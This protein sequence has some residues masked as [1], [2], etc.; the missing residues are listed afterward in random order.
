MI[1]RALAR[2]GYWLAVAAL[3]TAT[4]GLGAF[5]FVD[6]VLPE[7]AHTGAHPAV[8]EPSPS[9]GSPSASPVAGVMPGMGGAVPAN[10]DCSACHLTNAGAI[11]LRPIPA[12]GHPLDGWTKCTSCHSTQSLVATAPGHTGIHATACLTCHKPGNLPA[13]LS[14]P[15]R[16]RQNTACLDCHGSTAPLPVDMAHRTEQ[17][18]W[19]CH[20]LPDAQPPIPAHATV[21][22]ESDCL[23]CHVA[24][25]VGALPADHET[26][27]ASECLL[28]HDLPRPS[29]TPRSGGFARPERRAARRPEWQERVTGSPPVQHAEDPRSPVGTHMSAGARRS[30]DHLH[31]LQQRQKVE[32]SAAGGSVGRP[33][34]SARTCARVAMVVSPGKVV[35][36]TPGDT[37]MVTRDEVERI[38]RG[39]TARVRR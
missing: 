16:E 34:A 6:A 39:G 1:R 14:R 22:G 38:V 17:V 18:C 32:L 10:A 21:S 36:T 11:G 3:A 29:E 23:T 7:F 13:P 5:L 31:A 19:L 4:C 8:A 15:H 35:K 24:A 37:S 27:T 9:P 30:P 25:K 2:Y 28:C 33:A 12:M 20:R 26:R